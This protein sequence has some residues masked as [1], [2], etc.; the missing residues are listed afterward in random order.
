MRAESRGSRVKELG[1]QYGQLS[2]LV[3]YCAFSFL[4]LNTLLTWNMNNTGM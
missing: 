1:S 3:C 2:S 4:G